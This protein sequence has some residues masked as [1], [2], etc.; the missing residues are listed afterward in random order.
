MALR[1]ASVEH[2]LSS[3][4]AVEE[5][6]S[7]YFKM[8][9]IFAFL[10]FAFCI[11]H[12]AFWSSTSFSTCE[13]AETLHMRG[14]L[15]VLVLVT[16][17]VPGILGL[18]AQATDSIFTFHNAF[19]PNLHHFLYVVGRAER[20]EADARRRAVVRAPEDARAVTGATEAERQAWEAAVDVYK[21][22]L[23][24][25]NVIF[26][27]EI[28]SVSRELAI[29]GDGATL[30]GR[31]LQPE[32]RAVLER[33]APVYRKVWWPH[34]QAASRKRI[35]EITALLT[36]HGAAIRDRITR[37]YGLPW[38]A[39]G[40]SIHMSAYSNWAGAYSPAGGPIVMSS[41]D[42]G[43]A[44]TFGLESVFHEAMHQWDDEIFAVL[45]EDAQRQGTRVT[46]NLTHAMIFYT[47]GEATRAAVPEHVTY[48]EANGMWTG[49]PFAPFKA[50]LDRAWRPWLEGKTSRAEAIAALVRGD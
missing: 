31:G 20:G 49:G 28:I 29:A 32:L 19:W 17:F 48:A 9:C 14:A 33:A 36:T 26:D 18:K 23:S 4:E 35:D 12:F 11:L 13:S 7:V 27:R 15:I 30:E 2:S 39:G 10:H 47:A 1:R 3:K 24:S 25:Q 50:L 38:P 16:G 21:R 8:L 22:G 44:G 6:L 45:R 46:R 41:L 42:P 5:R 40:E 43:N 37:A 34:H